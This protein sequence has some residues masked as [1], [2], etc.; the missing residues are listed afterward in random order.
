MEKTSR[1]YLQLM[2]SAR[3]LFYRFGIR[4]VSVDEI[5]GKAKISKMTFYKYFR[6]KSEI[7]IV[8]IDDIFQYVYS[9]FKVI[10]LDKKPLK[11]TLMDLFQ[12]EEELFRKI[13]NEFLEDLIENNDPEISEYLI[14]ANQKKNEIIRDILVKAQRKGQ[15]NPGIKIDLLIYFI[16]NLRNLFNDKYIQELYPD[17][18]KLVLEIGSLIS[19]GILTT[20]K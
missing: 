15:L 7:A 6:G 10:P 20:K 8:V 17:R 18:S 9:R 4:R 13:G 11:E 16:Q 3:E 5:C 19:K 12:W 1:K 14:K 2:E